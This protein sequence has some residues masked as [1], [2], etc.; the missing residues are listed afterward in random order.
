MTV[1]SVRRGDLIR[2]CCPSFGRSVGPR[3][4][5]FFQKKR[6]FKSIGGR[7]RLSEY[8]EH[9]NVYLMYTFLISSNLNSKDY[10]FF[11]K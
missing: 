7:R 8:S 3:F 5:N 2:R 10:L 1:F 9:I 6:G 4:C 11:S